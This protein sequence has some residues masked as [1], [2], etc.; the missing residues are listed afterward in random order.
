MFRYRPGWTHWCW[1]MPAQGW[2]GRE[3]QATRMRCWPAWK[4]SASWKG[5]LEAGTKAS[6]Y[7][8][9]FNPGQDIDSVKAEYEEKLYSYMADYLQSTRPITSYKN[10]FHRAINDG[11]TFAFIAG[12]SELSGSPL[13]NTA[14]SWLN[15]RIDTELRFSDEL[16]RQL[17][18]LRDAE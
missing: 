12:W 17:K 4:R 6:T 15:G 18:E 8:F 14:Q 2:S 5:K 7:L 13:T 9:E 3:K 10:A 11:F 1:Q 16:F